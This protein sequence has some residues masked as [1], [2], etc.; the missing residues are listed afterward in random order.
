MSAERTFGRLTA[1]IWL[2]F[3]SGGYASVQT[4][5]TSLTSRTSPGPCL[6]RVSRRQFPAELCPGPGQS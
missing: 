5:V 6:C 2:M 1:G 3:M 4:N